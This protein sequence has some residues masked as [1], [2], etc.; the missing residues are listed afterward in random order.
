M[1]LAA[2]LALGWFWMLPEA[3]A[4]LGSDSFASAAFLAN[5]APLLQSGYFDIE[6]PKK[7]LLHLWSLGIGNSFI[8]SGRCS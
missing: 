6:S 3:F 8:C 5:I 1:V 7:P 4:R 2:T